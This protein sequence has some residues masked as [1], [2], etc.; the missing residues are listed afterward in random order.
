[1][2]T[3]SDSGVRDGLSSVTRGTLWL[4][5]GTICL[6][7][8]TFVYRVVLV[9]D[10][11]ADAWSAFSFGVALAALLSAFGTLG[12]PNAVARNIPYAT[13]D[14]ERR[15]YV[16][17]TLWV[18]G[19]AAAGISAALWFTA[20]MI[21][22]ALGQPD[23]G[24]GLQYFPIA[25]GSSIVAGLIASIFQGYEDVT[26]NAIYLQ[27]VNPAL[28]VGFLGVAIF[29]PSYGISFTEALIA[30][31]LA[32]ALTLAL[33]VVYLVRQLPRHLPPGPRAPRAF[34]HLLRFAAPL[35]VVG[36]MATVTTS[37]DTLVLGVF[38]AGEVGT[39]AASLTLAR[40]L[41]IGIVALGYIFLPVAARFLRKN[42][43]GAVVLTYTTVTKWMILISL[44]LFLLFFL[45][46]GS[47]LSFVYTSKYSAVVAP[48]QIAVFGAFLT[49]LLGPSN[50]A[51][52]AYGQTR[53]LMYNAVAAGVTDLALSLWLVPGLG[54]VGAAIAWGSA[55]ALYAGLSLAE[56]AFISGVHPFRRHF[57]V[58]L[59]ATGLPVGVV[60]AVFQ[61]RLPLFA[62]PLLGIGIAGLFVVFVLLTH[63]V[64]DGD[65]LLL[66]A[67]ERILGRPL[68]FL[69]RI[70]RYGLPNRP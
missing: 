51:Q 39:Y 41:Q 58:P 21:G 8:L 62:L 60:L 36:I 31:A 24:L 46:P 54:Y 5:I 3:D 70:G 67:V 2:A 33:L 68:P 53:L 57:V 16:R 56:L 45:L 52:V 69:R 40:L 48:L 44:P 47:S 12:L 27:V 43:A 26:P 65:R 49:T 37:G 13:T 9:R 17:G 15:A 7:G 34:G 30:Y 61:P 6:V 28:F 14:A 23:I 59:L 11:S 18:G 55:N 22:R 25:V 42:D 35:F 64:D 29:V 4:L 19:L 38:H 1:V 50:N 66:D 20:P 32:N 63:S 10:I